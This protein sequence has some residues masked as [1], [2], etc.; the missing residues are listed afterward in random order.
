M[1]PPKPLFHLSLCCLAWA[2][3]RG[4]KTAK[5]ARNDVYRAAN[6]LLRLAIDGRLCLCLRPPGYSC[7]RG[8][9]GSSVTYHFSFKR[10]KKMTA[11][12]QNQF[13]LGIIFGLQS[14]GKTTQTCQ[15]LWLYKEG[16][17]R[18]RGQG[19]E[20]MRTMESQVP[21]QRRRET[22]MQTMMRMEMM[23]MRV[24]D[25]QG[26]RRTSH[27]ASQ[28]TCTMSSVKMSASDDGGK[29]EK[30]EISC[31]SSPT[32]PHP[33][34]CTFHSFF[35]PKPAFLLV[36]VFFL[37]CLPLVSLP[38]LYINTI[39]RNSFIH[40][41]PFFLQCT[42]HIHVFHAVPLLCLFLSVASRNG[43]VWFGLI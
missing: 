16:Q 9:R 20:T 22:G 26:V 43:L 8:K 36:F 3:R 12:G 33:P 39:S 10:I 19:R 42:E 1:L 15:R 14:I 41:V 34:Q 38:S 35:L 25:A 31:Y 6:S 29:G 37:A 11:G 30:K 21:S 27:L 40:P 7:L 18:R 24:L 17:Q 13:I 32:F 4:Y 28:S 5:A 2:E 23:K